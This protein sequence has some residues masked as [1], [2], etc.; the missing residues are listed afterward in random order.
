MNKNKKEDSKKEQEY[1]NIDNNYSNIE[2]GDVDVV[3]IN[4][5]KITLKRGETLDANAWNPP[6]DITI[7][8]KKYD[9]I[10]VLF[11][12]VTLGTKIKDVIKKFKIKSGY[13]NL[14]MEV[15]GGGSGTT[16]IEN[17]LYEGNSSLPKD[18]LDC[19]I[20]FGY[21]KVDNG[22]EMVHYYNL[23]ESDIIYYIDICGFYDEIYDY[24]EVIEITIKYVEE[25]DKNKYTDQ[26][27]YVYYQNYN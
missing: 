2:K 24:N 15:A 4:D 20:T 7:N 25:K 14:N 18:F 8:D 26:Y 12:G 11:N 16:D 6:V 22:W 23:R 5:K 13:A 3:Y 1:S 10:P 27:G 9:S 17:V 19:R 21:K